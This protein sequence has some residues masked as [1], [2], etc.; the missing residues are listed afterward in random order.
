MDI[1]GT[2]AAYNRRYIDGFIAAEK[3]YM[4]CTVMRKEHTSASNCLQCGKCEK[5]CPQGLPIRQEL[6]NARKV[7]EGPVYQVAKRIV[8]LVI[9]Y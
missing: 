8:P 1:P 3:E 7:L 5:V 6:K 2:F 4:M 9:K